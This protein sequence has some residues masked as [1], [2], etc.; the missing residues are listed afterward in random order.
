MSSFSTFVSPG[1]G[2]LSEYMISGIPWVTS[3]QVPASIV[4]INF[5]NVTSFFAVKNTSANSI[6]VSFTRNGFSTGN[7]FTIASTEVFTADLRVKTLF[8][9]SSATSSY[10]LVAGVTTIPASN[11]PSL[12]G[13]VNPPNGWVYAPNVG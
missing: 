11:F 8:L 4:E 3:S 13:S 2:A 9:S 5:N 10:Q 6:N 1:A 12:T 7:F